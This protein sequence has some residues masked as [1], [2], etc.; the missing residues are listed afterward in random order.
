[1]RKNQ[2][3]ARRRKKELVM[4]RHDIQDGHAMPN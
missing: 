4:R 2:A 3:F 1:M